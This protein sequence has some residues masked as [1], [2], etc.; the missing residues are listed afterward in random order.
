MTT[1]T[2]GL[3]AT[4][5]TNADISTF[6]NLTAAHLAA[7]QTFRHSSF[8]FEDETVVLK[9]QG[10]LFRIHRH[11]LTKY[12][13]VFKDMW[14]LG[15]KDGEGSSDDNPILLN[16]DDPQDFSCLL[17]LFYHDSPGSAVYLNAV[18]WCS[19]LAVAT[20][21]DMEIIRQKAIQKIK[22]ANPPLDPIVQIVVAR[23]YDCKELREGPMEVLVKRAEPLSIEETVKLAPE[24]LHI[25][26]IGRDK[27]LRAIA[28]TVQRIESIPISTGR[29]MQRG[30]NW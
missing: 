6:D 2:S 21:Y 29:L 16:G 23:R 20:K 1:G 9:I 18:Q 28:N 15:S 27:S 17:Q 8:Y 26:I 30:Y 14:N 11:F 24:D 7:N 4:Q 22:L 25:W 5:L 19:V 3:S 10:V 13:P 12:S